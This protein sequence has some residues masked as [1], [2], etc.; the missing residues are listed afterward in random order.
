MKMKEIEP[1][2]RRGGGGGGVGRRAEGWDGLPDAPLGSA[3]DR[4]N[5]DGGIARFH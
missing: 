5:I 4:S 3:N 2:S 1:R